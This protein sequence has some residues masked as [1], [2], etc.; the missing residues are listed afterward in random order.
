MSD[1]TATYT[2]TTEVAG[3]EITHQIKNGVKYATDGNGYHYI[4]GPEN[5]TLLKVAD[6]HFVSFQKE[7]E[8]NITEKL[9]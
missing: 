8:T 9:E 1:E 3:K 6:R 2:V 5:E 7:P 4:Y